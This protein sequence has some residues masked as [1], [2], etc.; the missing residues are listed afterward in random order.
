MSRAVGGGG[1]LERYKPLQLRL[2]QAPGGGEQ[3]SKN[4]G[5]R[6]SRIAPC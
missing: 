5:E 6:E 1:K 2:A 4:G 3:G